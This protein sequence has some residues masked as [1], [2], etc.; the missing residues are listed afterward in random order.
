[1]KINNALPAMK[2]MVAFAAGALVAS[3]PAGAVDVVITGSSSNTYMRMFKD[4]PSFA[5]LLTPDKVRA[6]IQGW[7]VKGGILD[8]QDFSTDANGNSLADNSINPAGL[9]AGY[10]YLGQFIDHDITRDERSDLKTYATPASTV[11]FRTPF[12][13]LDSL[14]GAG[15]SVSPQLYITSDNKIK[16]IVPEMNNSKLL[17]IDGTTRFDVP[18]DTA[19]VAIIADSRNDENIMVSQMHVAMMM[20]HNAVV[21]NLAAQPAYRAASAQKVFDDA[22]QN[23]IWHYQW[24]VL[25]DYLPN[26]TLVSTLNDVLQNGVKFYH[27]ELT[28]NNSTL[29]DGTVLP[30]LPIEFAAAAF[31]FG[32]SQVRPTYRINR[33]NPVSVDGMPAASFFSARVFR[34]TIQSSEVNPNDLRGGKIGARRFVEWQNFFKFNDGSPVPEFGQ[35]ID[36]KLSSPLFELPGAG[37]NGPATALPNDGVQSLASRNLTRQVNFRIPSGQDIARAM[38]IT[39]LPAAAT[40]PFAPRAGQILTMDTSTPLWLYVLKE[41]ETTQDGARLGPVGSRI[42]DEVFVGLLRSDKASYLS[43]QPGWT[44]TLPSATVGSFNMTDLL[45]FAGAVHRVK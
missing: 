39:P 17:T 31:R 4:L 9:T 43:V 28:G 26:V 25:H 23:V 7:G 41:A 12:L 20:F 15:P 44:P 13:D 36:T 40:A 18:R 21:D 24:V 5:T 32:H 3:Q 6:E 42:V 1:M 33:T 29:S 45:R 27:P 8:A 16:F 2:K 37:S 11:N 34:S 22:R 30:K 35:A 14:Y 38:N 19:G 10:T